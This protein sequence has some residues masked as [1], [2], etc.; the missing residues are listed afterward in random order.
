MSLPTTKKRLKILLRMA[1][2]SFSEDMKQMEFI[3]FWCKNKTSKEKNEIVFEGKKSEND[4]R[5]LTK[6]ARII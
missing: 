6:Y 5:L 3:Y 1:I 4:I 2:L